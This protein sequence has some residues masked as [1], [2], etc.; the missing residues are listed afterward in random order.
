MSKSRC[1]NSD[2]CIWP[3]LALVAIMLVVRL[4]HLKIRYD[5]IRYISFLGQL[6]CDDL[7]RLPRV[8]SVQR[9]E[10][11]I[12]VLFVFPL[13]SCRRAARHHRRTL[14]LALLRVVQT[15]KRRM[16]SQKPKKSRIMKW[17]STVNR[18]VTCLFVNTYLDL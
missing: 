18:I 14:H 15:S 8:L 17:G 13:A 4:V 12:L 2:A 10:T 11:S 9:S 5:K 16:K 1:A 3:G 6:A 7:S